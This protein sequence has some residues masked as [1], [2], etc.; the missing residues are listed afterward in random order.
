M[1]PKSLMELATMACVKN[2]KALDSV[3]DYLPY[4]NV[5]YILLRVDNAHQL[6]QIELNSPHIQGET[7]EIWLKI[8]ER[9]FPLEYKANLYKPQDPKKWHRVW[10]KYKRDHDKNLEESEN[11]LKI[12]LAGLRQDKEQNTS[13]I[14]DRKLPPRIS[15][16][17]T[18]R[19]G[20]PRGEF[21]SASGML[22]GGG[23]RTKTANGASVMRKVRREVKEIA[24]IHGSLSKSI[25]APSKQ[26]PVR[27]APSAMVNDYQRASQPVY[28]P[29]VKVP[30]KLSAVEEHEQ[31]AAFLSE[32]E[33]EYDDDDADDDDE[34]ERPQVKYQH[35][36]PVVKS[37]AKPATS[38]FHKQFG[39]AR[40]PSKPSSAMPK[41][42]P[43]ILSNNPKN[44]TSRLYRREPYPSE[45]SKPTSK[46][47]T[48]TLVE[49]N[50]TPQDLSRT[51]TTP[52]RELRDQLSSSP[53]TADELLEDLAAVQPEAVNQRKRKAVNIFM[54]PK[55]RM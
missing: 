21:S 8:I 9:E 14:I 31:R 1:S 45:R 11:K 35:A 4:E 16:L 23:S 47:Q 3:G 19:G 54:R 39:Q 28:R 18:R 6:R 52:S 15:K 51:Q 22:F 25:R 43:G 32:S 33:E 20:G 48:S 2:I 13:K 38:S 34:P 5:R 53:R 24:N 42:M 17:A 40:S 27:Q 44:S 41:K 46:Q 30:E 10:E 12:A 49:E 50:N 26:M 37:A 55:K 29:T 7:G 36:K